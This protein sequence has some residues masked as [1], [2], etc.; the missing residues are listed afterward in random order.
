[1]Q[2]QI[3][4]TVDDIVAGDPTTMA[5]SHPLTGVLK[6]WT[7]TKASRGHRIVHRPNDSGGIHIGYV[8][9][10]EYEKAIQRLTLLEGISR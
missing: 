8:G 2:K 7:A 6:G 3:L 9:L 4:G 5:Q 10:H 1:M